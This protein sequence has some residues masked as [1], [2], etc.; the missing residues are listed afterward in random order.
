MT[1]YRTKPGMWLAMYTHGIYHLFTTLNFREFKAV[2]GIGTNGMRV[3]MGE[4]LPDNRCQQC[5][6]IFLL[7]LLGK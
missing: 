3:W 2:C 1:V 7:E 4:D 5:Q 6:S